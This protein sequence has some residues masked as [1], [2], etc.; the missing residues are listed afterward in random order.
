[1]ISVLLYRLPK[2]DED[3]DEKEYKARR[4]KMKMYKGVYEQFAALSVNVKG[5]EQTLK[6]AVTKL[7]EH[8][9][10]VNDFDTEPIFRAMYDIL[11]TNSELKGF[12]NESV[13]GGLDAI[14]HQI[15]T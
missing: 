2:K 11:M 13:S 8:T 1:M 14:Y 6:T 9:Q 12:L 15:F 10:M 3:E 7:V 4:K 5:S